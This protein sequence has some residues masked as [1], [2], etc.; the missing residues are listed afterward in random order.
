MSQSGNPEGNG[1]DGPRHIRLMSYLMFAFLPMCKQTD[2]QKIIN[3]CHC[4]N[5]TVRG[6]AGIRSNLS[7]LGARSSISIPVWV[8]AGLCVVINYSSNQM[9]PMHRQVCQV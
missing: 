4:V 5:V 3:E 9:S 8:G 6:K 1:E 7:L 2:A